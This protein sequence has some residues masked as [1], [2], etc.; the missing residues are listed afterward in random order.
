MGNEDI[1]VKVVSTPVPILSV[2]TVPVDHSKGFQQH[3]KKVLK[4]DCCIFK[5]QG[6]AALVEE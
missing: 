1:V 6:C 2:T 4:V 5:Q 3:K